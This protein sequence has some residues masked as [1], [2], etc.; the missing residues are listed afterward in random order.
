MSRVL[1]TGAG[2]LI[3]ARTL[4]TLVAAGHEVYATTRRA[5]D[6]DPRATW[7]TVDLLDPEA[8]EPLVRRVRPTHLLHLAWGVEHGSFWTSEDNVRWVQASLALVRA[9]IDSGGQRVVM[10]GS[11]AEYDWSALPAGAGELPRCHE[12]RTP[13]GPHTLYGES[14]HATHVAAREYADGAGASLAW[15]RLFFLYGPGEQ[16]GRLV[17]SVV[18]AL[19]AGEPAETTDGRQ[20]RDFLYVQDVADAFA[21]LL[22]SD[23]RGAVNIAS[24]D[25]T[26]VRT[27]VATIAEQLGGE[28]LVR[29]GAL[30]RSP[31]DPPTL[32]A[33]VTRLSDEVGFAP[34]TGLA[35][36]LARTID[37]WRAGEGR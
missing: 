6:H 28:A 10:A 17:P 26:T 29:W 20:V 1:V 7:H 27:V 5:G 18:R 13:V 33:D 23:V 25:P 12:Q 16:P 11:C 34:R 3:G 36:G 24:G 15:G 9:F 21:A 4:A 31:A 19:L 32:L 30:P 2:G 14:K 22:D 37:W 35:E 8:S